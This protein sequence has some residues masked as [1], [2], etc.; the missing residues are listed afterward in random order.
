MR[1]CHQQY[2]VPNHC[3]ESEGTRK[4][5]HRITFP[6][7]SPDHF[8]NHCAKPKSGLTGLERSREI[9]TC[10]YYPPQDPFCTS[11]IWP[12]LAYQP[13]IMANARLLDA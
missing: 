4:W 1:V 8:W 9:S 2:A 6:A 7:V 10:T 13:S 12:H 3:H 11:G 5:V